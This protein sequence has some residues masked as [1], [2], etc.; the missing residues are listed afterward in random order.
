MSSNKKQGAAPAFDSYEVGNKK[1]PKHSQFQ[2]G[3][4]GN[5]KGRPKGSKNIKTLM[6]QEFLKPV[7][8]TV[9]GKSRKLPTIR[10][11][12]RKVNVDALT[13]GYREAKLALDM[14]AKY[15]DTP[16]PSTI[17]GLMAG[18]SPFELTPEEYEIIAKHKLLDEED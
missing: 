8:L 17:D 16:E 5:P 14:Y 11:I 18:Q 13:C 4:S 7:K 9:N 6:K 1:P 10:A 2:K 15:C 3:K 12:V